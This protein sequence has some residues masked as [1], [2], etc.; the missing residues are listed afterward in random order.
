MEIIIKGEGEIVVRF[1]DRNGRTLIE[2]KYVTS[3][4]QTIQAKTEVPLV[5]ETRSG[6]APLVP[7]LVHQSNPKQEV[8]FDGE[9]PSQFCKKRC[10]E[11]GCSS[12]V[13]EDVERGCVQ[14]LG[15]N[16]PIIPVVGH[17]CPKQK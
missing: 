16:H 17:S 5:A 7:V 8:T 2:R 9:K 1:S 13:A 3:G 6:P 4:S 14:G 12:S 11:I 15:V 10:Q